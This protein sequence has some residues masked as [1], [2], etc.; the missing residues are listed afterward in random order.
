MTIKANQVTNVSINAPK[1]FVGSKVDIVIPFHGQY[2]KVTRLLESIL[3]VTKSNPYK[4]C[5]VDDASPNNKFIEALKRHPSILATRNETHLGFGA[6]LKKGFELSDSPWVCFLHSDCVIQDKNWLVEMGKSLL[7]LKDKKVRLISARSNN[8]GE[9]VD[10]RL[11]ASKDEREGH[12]YILEEGFVP[13][14]CALCHRDLFKHIGGFIKPYPYGSYEDEELAYR[15]RHFGYK[16]GICVKSWVYHEGSATINTI[17]K[18]EKVMGILDEN[19]EKCIQD[20]KYLA[21]KNI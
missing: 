19:R 9:H 16:Q 14:Y 21:N 1:L 11:L 17:C 13:L 15:M 7:R 10:Q 8:P 4:I 12:D 20:M 3:Y 5:L 18:S 6:S 2:D